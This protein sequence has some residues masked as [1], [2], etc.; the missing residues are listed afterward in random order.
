MWFED[1][2]DGHPGSHLWYQNRRILAVL[3]LYVAYMPP[4]RFQLNPTNGFGG[5]VVKEEILAILNLHASSMHPAKFQ[6]NLTYRSEGDVVWF[7]RWL[8]WRPV[9]ISEQNNFS[10]SESPCLPNAS[11][12]VW[13]QSDLSFGSRIWCGLNIFKT[14][15]MAPFLDIRISEHNGF[16]KSESPYHPNTSHQVWAQS[17]LPFWSR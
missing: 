15:T 17:D 9:W 4:I 1:F 8:P 14:A 3:N 2:E 16:S 13:A 6:L 10:N 12:Q 5:D 11:H 7:S